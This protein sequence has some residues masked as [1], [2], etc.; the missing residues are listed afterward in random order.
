MILIDLAN[1]IPK[2][3]T[4]ITEEKVESKEADMSLDIGDEIS[5]TQDD[6]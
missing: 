5:I 2:D 4:E 1:L 6:Q 3:S